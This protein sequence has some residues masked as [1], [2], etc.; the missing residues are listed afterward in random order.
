MRGADGS[1]TPDFI[2]TMITKKGRTFEE[3]L[4]RIHGK[5]L[6]LNFCSPSLEVYPKDSKDCHAI[7]GS[8]LDGL[9]ADV[10]PDAALASD[11]DDCA[12][13]FRRRCAIQHRRT[14][15]TKRACVSSHIHV[16]APETLML[17]THHTTQAP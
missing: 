16:C 15:G 10:V 1:E 17:K 8:G 3:S 6:L 14:N 4:V 13:G 12:L 11:A 2:R 7:Y 9:A 5:A